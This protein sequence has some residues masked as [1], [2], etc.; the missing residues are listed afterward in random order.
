MKL[1]RAQFK[2]H[3]RDRTRCRERTHAHLLCC[4]QPQGQAVADKGLDLCHVQLVHS[5][6]KKPTPAL[7]S[8]NLCLIRRVRVWGLYIISSAAP[9]HFFDLLLSGNLAGRLITSLLCLFELQ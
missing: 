5:V 9:S 1:L 4:R 3:G 8:A 2:F 7:H 6:I